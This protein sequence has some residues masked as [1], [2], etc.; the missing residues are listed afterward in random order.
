[1]QLKFEEVQAA[2]GSTY[3]GAF[4]GTPDKGLCPSGRIA[5]LRGA[6]STVIKYDSNDNFP[7]L[8]WLNR[9]SSD[10]ASEAASDLAKFLGFKS[11]LLMYDTILDEQEKFLERF[12]PACNDPPAQG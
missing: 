12:S 6:E 9:N 10:I 8:G 11:V 3:F 4:W 2:A 5:Q 7:I 1:M